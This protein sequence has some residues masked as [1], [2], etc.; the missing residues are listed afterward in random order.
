MNWREIVPEIDAHVRAT[1]K[2]HGIVIAGSIVRGEA[3]PTSDFD[4]F[5]VHAEPSRL[6]DRRHFKT[7]PRSSIRRIASAAT[8]RASSRRVD[9]CASRS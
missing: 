8:S 9:R 7:C 5:I 3:D 1:Y 6:R 4:V 2:V